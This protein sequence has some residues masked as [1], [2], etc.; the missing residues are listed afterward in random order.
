M[1][2]LYIL[3]SRSADKYY[4]GYSNNVERRINEHNFSE[5]T[6]YTSKHRPWIIVAVYSCGHLESEAVKIERFIKKQKS[7]KLIEHLVK[8]DEFS[9]ILA[10]LVRVPQ[11]R[12]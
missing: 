9:G 1:Y 8:G 11:V 3:Y 6:T 12:D 7:R 10:P 2:Y 4:V 5:R